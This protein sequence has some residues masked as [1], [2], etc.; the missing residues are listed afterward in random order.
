ML[1]MFLV[2]ENGEE[3]W[4]FINGRTIEDA[5]RHLGCDEEGR[6]VDMVEVEGAAADA[7]MALTFCNLI[8]GDPESVGGTLEELVNEIYR[9]G[10]ETTSGR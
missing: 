5:Q 4:W 2:R 1:R 9:K 7:I 6:V 8:S 10:R 3:G